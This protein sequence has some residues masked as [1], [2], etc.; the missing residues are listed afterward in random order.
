MKA[1]WAFL[2]GCT[3]LTVTTRSETPPR[4]FGGALVGLFAF[5]QGVRTIGPLTLP[6]A[7]SDFDGNTPIGVSLLLGV[8]VP[9][10]D[11]LSLGVAG[12]YSRAKSTLVASESTTFNVRGNAVP[13]RFEHRAELQWEW[14]FSLAS[15]MWHVNQGVNFDVGVGLAFPIGGYVHATE[16]IVEPDGITYVN[17]GTLRTTA[18]ASVESSSSVLPMLSARYYAVLMKT[19]LAEVDIGLFYNTVLGSFTDNATVSPSSAGGCLTVIFNL[20]GLRPEQP[21]FRSTI[22]RDTIVVVDP[23]DPMH[24]QVRYLESS[25]TVEI[26]TIRP[27]TGP[28][29]V[30]NTTITIEK[31]LPSPPPFLSIVLRTKVD[32]TTTPAAPSIIVNADVVADEGISSVRMY[33]IVNTDTIWTSSSSTL[34]VEEVHWSLE[35]LPQRYQTESSLTIRIEAVVT[36]KLNQVQR[37]IPAN[38]KISR[39]IRGR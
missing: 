30:S 25:R 34:P 12:G 22:R 32:S 7:S 29:V 26:D 16:S 20:A 9:F 28:I 11:N 14:V 8:E 15:L 10:N 3:V 18:D 2:L 39:S 5:G 33:G 36:D 19:R 35:Q 38:I 37:A 23:Y 24:R 1:L 13:G 6:P 17:G 27:A 21:E 4:L 31:H